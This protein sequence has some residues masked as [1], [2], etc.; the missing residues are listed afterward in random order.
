[1]KKLLALATVAL[2]VIAAPAAGAK[3]ATTVVGPAATPVLYWNSVAVA[4]VRSNPGGIPA[5][6]QTEGLVY[7]SYV[8]AAVYDAVTAIEGRY[9]P[10]HAF[11]AGVA[12]GGA[13]LSAAVAAAT[14]RIFDVD[15]PERAA[16][17]DAAYAAYVP[18]LTDG[19][20]ARGIAIGTAAADDVIAFRSTD[21]R[22]AATPPVGVPFPYTLENAGEWQV[23]PPFAVAQTPW[24]ANMTPFVLQSSSQFRPGPPPALTSKQYAD[25][26][27][28]VQAYGALS[29]TVRT[30]DQTATAYFWNA[31]TINQF[32]QLLSDVVAQHGMDLVDAAHLLAMGELVSTDAAIA[33][34][35]A[36]YHF[37][38][39]R[40]YSAIRNADLDGNPATTADPGWTPLLGT[41]NHPE[42]PSAHGCVT[43]AVTQAIKQA[44][45]TDRID[46]TFWGA[47]N[48]GS[49]LAL[50]R[51]YDN[52]QQVDN[53]LQDA[54]VWIGF[55]YRNS[56]V[57]GEKLAKDVAKYDL[58]NAFRPV[59]DD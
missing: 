49:A 26:L 3:Q 57:V 58:R 30:A 4:A 41:P 10:Y 54:R 11:D 45:G 13:S 15:L 5:R 12:I 32:N 40:P 27:N 24:V 48:G 6:F 25:D 47:V 36:K 42:Y 44:L 28:E 17:V 9:V 16:A 23:V 1:M 51:H 59:D 21:G 43:G 33:C 2:A 46:V 37:L 31:N 53:E 18:G 39:W 55:H 29:S 50:T 38:L 34:F 56:V 35:D 7:M 14:K 19:D 8:Q 52:V 22:N 20:V